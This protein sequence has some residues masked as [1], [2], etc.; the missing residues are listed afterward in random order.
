[1]D[2][3]EKIAHL[4][5]L[6]RISKANAKRLVEW[7]YSTIDD[8]EGIE[9]A[10]L[11][12]RGL[13]W[14]VLKKIISKIVA[15]GKK[16]K[17]EVPGP[18]WTPQQWQDFLTKLVTQ[19]L[20]TWQEIAV[21]TLGEMNPPQVGTSL[22]TKSNYLKE[23]FP[24]KKVMAAVIAWL[25][26]QPGRC[27][28]C[29]T[30]LF[31]EV[32]HKKGKH[33]FA[34]EGRPKEEADTLP[35]LQLLCRRCNVIKR[36]SHRLGGSSFATTQATLIWIILVHQP[37]TLKEFGKLCRKYGLT[38]SDVRFQEAWALAEWLRRDNLYP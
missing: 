38:Q 4:R 37:L 12:D 24:G 32:D 33:E 31:L 23:Q 22:A 20:T 34:R 11:L 25:Y 18:D 21:A 35:N 3:D 14:G 36:E 6:F 26:S 28:K 9:V 7:G 16:P 2:T 8:F 30:R 13:S 29:G 19:G 17:W 10:T 15:E 27:V 1:M 5:S